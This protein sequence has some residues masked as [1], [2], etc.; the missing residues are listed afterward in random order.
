MFTSSLSN[1]SLQLTIIRHPLMVS[2]KILLL[3]VVELINQTQSNFGNW[4]IKDLQSLEDSTKEIGNIPPQADSCVLV[5]ENSHLVGIFTQRDLITLTAERKS[6]ENITI[7]EVMTRELVTLNIRD[8]KDVFTALNLL[9][10]HRIRHLPILGEKGEVIGLITP[11]SLLAVSIHQAGL[12]NYARV[13]LAER[14]RIETELRLERNFVSAVLN[15]AD[16]LVVVL[17]CQGRIVRFNHTCEQTT[18]YSFEEVKDKLIW[19]LL[20]LPEKYEYIKAV[21]Q[22][23]AYTELPNRYETYLVTKYSDRHLISWS[24]NVLLN[25]DNQV[26]YIVCT[27]IN[28][29]ESRKAQEELQQTRNFLQ[30]M[31]NNLPVAVFV[32]DAKPESFGT[33]KLWNQTCERIFGITAEQAIG[34]TGYELFP[35]EQADLFRQKDQEALSSGI[36]QDIPE[37]FID[38][39]SFGRRV[40]HTT[41][42]P[43]Y[44]KNQQ[45]EYL[46]CISDDITEYKQAKENLQQAKEQLQ[47]VLDAVPGFVSWVSI[48][49][50]YLGVNRH[51]AESFNFTSDAFVGE[52]LGFMQNSQQF[53]EFMHDFLARQ[54]V[55]NSKVIDAQING[56]I[57]N[58]LLVAQKY[59][60][61]TAAV[62]VGIDITERKQ[63]EIALAKSESMLRSLLISTP[64]IVTMV[65]RQGKILFINQKVPNLSVEEVIGKNIHNYVFSHDCEI[66]RSA[67][68]RVFNYGEVVNYEIRTVE[69]NAPFTYYDCQAGPIWRD[70]QVTDAV[71][72]LNN[73]SERKQ[74]EAALRESEQKFRLFTENIRS[75]FWI[76]DIRRDTRQIVYVSPAFE[77]IW[78]RSTEEAYTSSD[79]FLEAIHPSDRQ[80]FIADTPKRSQGE[81]DEEYRIVRPDGAIR[82]IRSRAFPVKNDKGEVYRITGIAEDIT[83]RKQTEIALKS[84]VESTAST[85]GHDFFPALVEYI[86][87]ALDL[88]HALVSELINGQVQTLGFWS[89]G[90]LQPNICYELTSTPYEI[91]LKQGSYYSY[92]EIQQLFPT[93]ERWAGMKAESSMGVILSDDFGNSIGSLCIVDKKPIDQPDKFEG[94]LK[95]FAARA[96]AELQRKRAQEALQQL[97]R[98]LEVRV[99]QRTLELQESEAELRAIFNQAAV[100]IKLESLDGRFLKVNQKLCEILG[101]SQEDLLNKT[102]MDITYS[103]DIQ[104]HLNN[105]QKLISGEVETFSIEKRCLHKNGN[106]I[107]VN[108]T[109]S[110]IRDGNAKP[111]YSIGIVKD[112]QSQ[113]LAQDALKQQIERERLVNVI[114]QRIRESL[115]LQATLNVTVAEIHKLLKVDRVLIYR[116]LID[117]YGKVIAEALTPGYKSILNQSF[118]IECFPN[119]SY[120]RYVNGHIYALSDRNLRESPSCLIQFMEDM[121][122][123]A[124]LVI[125][126]IHNDVL[127]GLL[128][129]HQCSRPKEWKSGEMELLQQLANQLAIATQQ[130]GLYAQLQ[131]E[132]NER[133][134]AEEQIC[135]ALEKEKELSDLKSRFISMTS[136]EFRTPLA[137][138]A[139]SAG[140]LKSFSH[141]LDEQQKQ[142]HLQCIQTY[143]QHTTQLLDDI[144]LINKAEAGK[145]AFDPSHFD[146]VGFCHTLIDELQLSSP[147]HNLVFYPQYLDN[148]SNKNNFI[149]YMDNKLLRQ[150]LSNL[151]SNAVKYSSIGTNIQIDLLIQAQLAVFL[152]KDEGIGIS[153]EDQQHLFESFYRGGNVGNTPGT[154]LGLTITNKCVYLHK[155]RITFASKLGV[156]TT[157]KVELPLIATDAFA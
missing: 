18:G 155:G 44:D 112:I 5:V 107:W 56:T 14:Q 124:K 34:K 69:T 2:P 126:I 143:V 35:K 38:S 76:A 132:L 111:I 120:L 144:L 145:L 106:L 7:E 138:I 130:S 109:C 52:E 141:K 73:V 46:L 156:G 47:T 57:R 37:E 63:A 13:K 48:D 11:A 142:K 17:D 20:L 36:P 8:F 104:C 40:L 43:L 50:Y 88:R 114:T 59:Q 82:W 133:K 16:A 86:A 108:L 102:Y 75:T 123:R 41:K 12:Y 91:L 30:S 45:P 78:G 98:D 149:A 10:Q 151:L 26:E 110:L 103:D 125:P 62:V 1:E 80:R 100:G 97:N 70:G 22:N 64:N 61:N 154:G 28:I 21:F 25:R 139:S 121:Q 31:I 83:E 51:L 118:P 115:D 72:V 89:D 128:I 79:T 152:I 84:L 58:Y 15:V 95:V 87:S 146:L 65:N 131:V 6:L 68:E 101:Y 54:D 42:I 92:S 153:L 134:K 3:D 96:S 157:F 94:I 147:N 81:H 116:T 150:I 105:L 39:P 55:A 24:N 4:P 137:V 33:F 74:T 122:I 85:T 53:T 32:K 23:L 113:K 27:G 135:K 99:E 90:Q 119:E 66:Q 93:D 77:E 71:I 19:D 129:T 29:T 117:G 148:S 60:Q 67:L 49:G 9:K 136:H 127:W 140:I